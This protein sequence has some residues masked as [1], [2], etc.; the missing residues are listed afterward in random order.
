ME[1][2]HNQYL[3]IKAIKETIYALLKRELGDEVR[4]TWPEPN[5]Y[6]DWT[7]DGLILVVD[8]IGG[9]GSRFANFIKIKSPFGRILFTQSFKGSLKQL[10]VQDFL[11]DPTSKFK[12]IKT[13]EYKINEKLDVLTEHYHIAIFKGKVCPSLVEMDFP[14]NGSVKREKD[15]TLC[16]RQ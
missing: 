13:K 10:L 14:F 15:W 8:W 4:D 1:D 9:K 3:V 6:Y 16:C 2:I 7:C 12:L 5:N 11:N